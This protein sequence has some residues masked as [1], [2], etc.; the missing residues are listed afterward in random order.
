MEL[1]YGR[2]T[3]MLG[4]G[5]VDVVCVGS[6]AKQ[7]RIRGSMRK[8]EWVRVH[9]I[10]LVSCREFDKE[11]ADIVFRYTDAEVQKLRKWGEPLNELIDAPSRDSDDENDQVVFRDDDAEEE[12]GR[13][14]EEDHD[15]LVVID[16]I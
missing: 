3:K 15:L 11:K 9:D 13:G 2:V 5:R 7:C 10:V 8:R 1:T 6:I 12:D 14:E 16:A 4:N